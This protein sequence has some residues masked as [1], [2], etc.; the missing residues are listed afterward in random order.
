MVRDIEHKDR[1]YYEYRINYIAKSLIEN[2]L[3]LEET[4]SS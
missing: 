2:E 1:E 4:C 3:S